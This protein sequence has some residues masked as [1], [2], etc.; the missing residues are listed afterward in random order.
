MRNDDKKW[1]KP[2]I[3]SLFIFICFLISAQLRFNDAGLKN[4]IVAREV[5]WNFL[6][7]LDVES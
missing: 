6:G 2:E 3:Y 4:V 1:P 5:M 7:D